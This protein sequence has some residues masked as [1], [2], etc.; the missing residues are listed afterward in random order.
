MDGCPRLLPFLTGTRVWL[1]WFSFTNRSLLQLPLSAGWYSRAEHWITELPSQFSYD[2]RI[3]AHLRLN[4][5]LESQSVSQSVKVRVTLR[6]AVYHQSVRL[7]GKPLETHDQIFYFTTD[8]LRLQSLCNIL[9]DERTGLS[10][11]IAAD[12]R[13]SNHSQVQVPRDSVSDSRLPQPGGPCLRIYIPPEQSVPVIPSG[14]GFLLRRLLRLAGLRWR[15]STPPPHRESLATKKLW[16]EVSEVM[17]TVIKSVNY[18]KTRPLKSRNFAA[19]CEEM[20]GTVGRSC[21]TV[22]LVGC[23][24]ETLWLL[25]SSCEKE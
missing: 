11:T 15:Y 2:C 16:P 9:S 7:G 23:Q 21:F 19:S 5:T 17:D 6:L 8:Y 24:D 25:L 13:Q 3:M 12:P 22:I 1:T 18:M 14:T 20:G 4:W 10:F